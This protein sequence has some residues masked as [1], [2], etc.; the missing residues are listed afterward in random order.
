MLTPRDP[1]II[2]PIPSDMSAI[3]PTMP[4]SSV[5]SRTSRFCTCAISW[6]TTP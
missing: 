4:A 2:R 6:A 1:R 5:I 3:A